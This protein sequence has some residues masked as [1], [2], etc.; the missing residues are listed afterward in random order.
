MTAIANRRSYAYDRHLDAALSNWGAYMRADMEAHGIHTQPTRA[1][2]QRDYRPPNQREE[3]P[4]P[5]PPS[6]EWAERVQRA[7]LAM[8][9][10]D[11]DAAT[12]LV[13]HYRDGLTATD[14]MRERRRLRQ[15]RGMFGQF[16]AVA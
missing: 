7:V 1:G 10:R 13:R 5:E 15:A 2:W 8:M 6:E 12:V 16:Y 4:P 11:I 3:A 14:A 9:M